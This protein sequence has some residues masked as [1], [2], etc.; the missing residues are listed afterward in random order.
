MRDTYFIM[1][2]FVVTDIEE[3]E[4]ME[5]EEVLFGAVESG[6]E[7]WVRGIVGA[8]LFSAYNWHC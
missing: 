7:V 2:Q 8:L 6:S 3:T 5:D 4:G 1:E